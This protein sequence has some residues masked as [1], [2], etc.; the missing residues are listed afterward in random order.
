MTR[1]LHRSLVSAYAVAVTAVLGIGIRDAAAAPVAKAAA[2]SCT[3]AECAE[4]CDSM[5]FMYD[6]AW[7]GEYGCEC[8]VKMCG[9][10]QC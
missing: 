5:G 3:L 7:C 1:H 10:T 8:R 2:A 9:D 6:Y 4:W